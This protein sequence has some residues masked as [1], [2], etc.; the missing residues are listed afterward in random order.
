MGTKTLATIRGNIMRNVGFPDETLTA[1]ATIVSFANINLVNINKI[2][3]QECDL[4]ELERLASKVMTINQREY[5]L[6]IATTNGFNLSD[7]RGQYLTS[8]WYI[9][10]SGQS[11]E[12]KYLTPLKW[13]EKVTVQ[14]TINSGYPRFYTI[15]GGTISFDYKPDAAYTLQLRYRGYATYPGEA[16]TFEFRNLD[17]EIETLGTAL[18]FLSMEELEKAG[19]WLKM[20]EVLL[21]SFKLDLKAL[22]NFTTSSQALNSSQ[23]Q[24]SKPWA[25]PFVS[26][27]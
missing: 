2:L 8:I 13:D 10:S 17:Q 16:A 11:S 27:S 24:S 4:P 15:Y 9:N 7:M 21:K 20:S 18:T 3:S 5:N 25:D 1:A 19:A 6:W 14:N 22:F 23:S 12:V 26:N